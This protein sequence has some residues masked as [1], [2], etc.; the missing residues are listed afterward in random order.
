MQNQKCLA[1]VLFENPDKVKSPLWRPSQGGYAAHP[2]ASASVRKINIKKNAHDDELG[3]PGEHAV[4]ERSKTN[5]RTLQS[6]A[7]LSF[8]FSGHASTGKPNQQGKTF[9]NKKANCVSYRATIVFKRSQEIGE[10][11]FR[12]GLAYRSRNHVP[13]SAVTE[14]ATRA[15]TLGEAGHD[16]QRVNESTKIARLG[17]F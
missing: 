6:V 2:T 13:L 4:E 16:L 8:G 7:S 5:R 10:N 3:I 9:K 17:P 15:L 11:H 1:S 12:F 14:I